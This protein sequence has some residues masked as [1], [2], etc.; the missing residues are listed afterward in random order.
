MVTRSRS[1]QST[2]EFVMILAIFTAIGILIM[3]QMTSV[4]NNA[5][6]TG[7]LQATNAVKND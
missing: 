3:T 1:G 4:G 5:I 6:G 2:T 7:E